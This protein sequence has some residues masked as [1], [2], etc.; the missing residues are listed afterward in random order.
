MIAARCAAV[1]LAAGAVGG[2]G[3][4]VAH[5]HRDLEL[6]A[7]EPLGLVGLGVQQQAHPD[8]GQGDEDRHDQR[9][10]HRDVAPQAGA[11]LGEDVPQLHGWVSVLFSAGSRRRRGPG[12]VRRA[13]VELD[14]ALAHL[15]D[16]AGVVG[17]HHHGGAGAVDPV[18]Q[19][20]DADAGVRVEVAGGLVGDQDLGPVDER[21]RDRDALLLAAGEL[22]GHPAPLA[23]QADQLEG[24]GHHLV[25]VRRAACRSPGGRR[26]RSRATVLFGSSRKSWKTVPIWRRSAGHL[27]ARAAVELLAGDV[28]LPFG[29]ARL[30]QHQAQ[31]GR[32]ARAGLADEEDELARGRCRR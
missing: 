3:C 1:D 9:D 20:H 23:L 17:G 10:R 13:V 31:E 22:V 29:G 28:D 25:D 30:A 32:L 18:E 5:E 15:V 24:L 2:L 21:P 4:W 7:P 14:D 6:A 11:G 16:D 19:L 27:P 12:R 8:Q 26:R